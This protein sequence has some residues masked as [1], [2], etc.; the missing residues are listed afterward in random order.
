MIRRQTAQLTRLVDDLLDVSRITRGIVNLRSTLIDPAE[1]LQEAAKATE[2]LIRHK[3]HR[4]TTVFTNEPLR[5]LGDEAR[6]IQ[7]FTNLLN[8]AAKYTPE[9]GKID[10]HLERGDG[11]AVIRVRDNGIGIEP[12]L[13]ERIFDLFEQGDRP[14][15]RSEGVLG[16]GLTLVRKIVELHHGSVVAHS[17]GRDQG[18]EIVVRLPLCAES[19]QP[20]PPDRPVAAPVSALRILVV[21]DN[22]DA[23]SSM[24]SLL[25]LSGHEVKTQLTGTGALTTALAWQPEVVLLDIGLPGMDGYAVARELRERGYKGFVAA[26]TGYGQEADRAKSA[27]AGF[28]LH[29]VKPVDFEKLRRAL[30]G[31]SAGKPA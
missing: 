23:A 18:C 6:L 12:L 11:Q 16:I 14:L 9:G 2:R 30:A 19:I 28:D 7:V 15:A 20:P 24:S 1:V 4:L 26:L 3:R 21:D 31:K 13:L 25:A 8:N 5:V 10:V 29:L 22:V 27:A 17:A